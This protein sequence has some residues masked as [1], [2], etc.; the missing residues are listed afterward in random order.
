MRDQ[1]SASEKGSEYSSPC[2]TCA[3]SRT[4][5]QL[6]SRMSPIAPIRLQSQSRLARAPSRPP[7]TMPDLNAAAFSAPAEV[8]V[9]AATSRS[10][11]SSSR[12]S[13]PQ[14]K[15]PWAPPPCSARLMVRVAM[16]Q[17]VRVRA[18]SSPRRR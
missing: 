12:S 11:S 2:A 15:A 14:V 5:A 10:S 3:G 17:A 1:V 8:P 9:I 6:L 13:T 4:P 18:R 7:D 16:A